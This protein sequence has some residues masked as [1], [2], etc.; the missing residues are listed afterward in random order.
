M[1][2]DI[3][4][5]GVQRAAAFVGQAVIKIGEAVLHR[6]EPASGRLFGIVPELLDALAESLRGVVKLFSVAH[7]THDSRS[8]HLDFSSITRGWARGSVVRDSSVKFWGCCHSNSTL[9][10]F[11]ERYGRQIEGA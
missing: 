1:G 2:L 9:S 10:P 7:R 4:F 5:D 11:L 6:V 8:S 3:L